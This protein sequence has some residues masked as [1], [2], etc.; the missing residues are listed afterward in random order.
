MCKVKRK[1]CQTPRKAAPHQIRAF[2]ERSRKAI[3]KASTKLFKE[4]VYIP[5]EIIQPDDLYRLLAN[6]SEKKYDD[7][8]PL[9]TRLFFAIASPDAFSQLSEAC[10][11]VRQEQAS[12]S[13]TTLNEVLPPMQILDHLDAKSSV[14]STLRRFHLTRLLDRRINL[15]NDY[16]NTRSR[17]TTKQ[18]KHDSKQLN[19]LLDRGDIRNGDERSARIDTKAL[20]D[21]MAE[22]YPH[23][24]QP[25]RDK[26]AFTDAK[27]RDRLSK[28]QNRLSCA[29][30][31][32]ALQQ[33][34]S[35][36]ILA[37][38]PCGGEFQIQIDRVERLPS[39]IFSVFLEVLFEKRGSFL[40][41]VSQS[42]SRH[43]QNIVYRKDLTS[44][45][46][47]ETVDKMLLKQEPM[48]SQQLIRFCALE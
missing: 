6:R 39:S 8:L 37:L 20:T 48:D 43:I 41:K 3:P 9:L 7:M 12:P 17:R 40:V 30:N 44:K 46:A 33:K 31:W 1:S 11:T 27:Y 21:I 24:K 35:P 38:V 34:C 18:R 10:M 47:F 32:H 15:G 25:R 23:L 16:K 19:G 36:G 13:V 4:S 28:L 29:R 2:G 45:Y 42:V 26:S 5:P 22:S 14:S